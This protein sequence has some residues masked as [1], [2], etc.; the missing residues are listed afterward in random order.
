MPPP[1][2]GDTAVNF[3]HTSSLAPLLDQLGASLL[4][5]T[6]QAGKVLVVGVQGDQLQIRFHD[7]EQ[8]MGLART[9]TG[10]A[11]GTKRQI[12]QLAAAPDLAAKLPPAGTYDGCFL[13]RSAHFT[14]SVMSHELAWGEGELWMANT[15]FSCVCTVGPD[16][17]FA[18]RWKP[19]FVSTLAGEDR[20]HLNGLALDGGKP[21]YVTCLG[22]TDS[23]AGWRPGKAEGGCL[24]HVPTDAV[25][26][27]G[28]SMPHSPRVHR[29]G[30]SCST[31]VAA[32]C[33]VATR[34][35]AGSSRWPRCPV[36]PAVWTCSTGSRSS[37]CRGFGRRRCSAGCRLPSVGPS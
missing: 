12:W 22:E 32:G 34:R 33:A 4:I 27:R 35:P 7:F 2:P 14:G 10:I 30:C 8:A 37:G 21:A 9:P 18:P 28:L 31:R 6:Y 29:A 16:A 1:A 17:H 23:A 13:A 26:A 15:L 19:P 25:V 3:T 24:V 36:T 5:S 11:I 20:C